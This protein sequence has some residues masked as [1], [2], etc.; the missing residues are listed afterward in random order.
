MDTTT[1]EAPI[2]VS[3]IIVNY[4]TLQLLIDTIS[5]VLEK[6]EGFKFEIIVVDNNSK[7]NAQKVLS[8]KFG[9][10][11]IYSYLTENI[12]FGRANNEGLKIARG[13][14]I[15][16][17]N[18]DTLLIN[19]AIKILN[20]YLNEN[21]EVG[22]CGGN[23]FDENLRPTESYFTKLPSLFAELANIVLPSR[24]KNLFY[25]SDEFFN[26][27]ATPKSV[28]YVTGAD[29]MIKRE[30]IEQTGGFNPVFFMYYEETELSYRVSKLGY[31][32][33]S[34]PSAEIIHL[35][36]K[37]FDFN[38]R[39]MLMYLESKFK[40]FRIVYSPLHALLV[41]LLIFPL[42]FLREWYFRLTFSV[43]KSY[44]IDMK[45]VNKKAWM[46]YKSQFSR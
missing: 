12:G 13:K 37:S 29:L 6:S 30:V 10:L 40:F 43:K 39:R 9:E 18:S 2:D 26:T 14:N 35:E 5:S 19:N 25:N 7:E 27:S 17:L 24:L 45:R 33:M 21:K 31:K 23:L 22:I 42:A 3:I 46:N 16:F 20:D 32:I 34:I 28:A 36:G 8:D 41:Y 38:E 15:F 1:L 44:W 4:N 11:V